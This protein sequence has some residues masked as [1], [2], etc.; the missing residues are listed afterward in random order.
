[1]RTKLFIF[2]FCCL[3]V[4]LFAQT[5]SGGFKVTGLLL[6]SLSREPVAYATIKIASESHPQKAVKMLVTD[7]KG[8]FE[9][10]LPGAGKY[11][12]T[13]SSVGNRTEVRL[14][15]VSQSQPKA[16]LGTV[17]ISEATEELG[18]VTV[19]AQKP[20]VKVEVDKIAYDVESDPDAQD[21]TVLDMLRKVPL[22]TVDGEDNIKL[23]GKTNFRIHL[24][25]RPSNL[26]S[27]NPG[28]TLKSMP[29][30]SVKDIEVITSPGAKYD[31][32]GV[33]GIINIVT[34]SG[35][36]LEGYS[37]TLTAGSNQNGS[38][39]A[40]VS[41]VVKVG[42]LSVSG[43]YNH[44]YYRMPEIP[45]YS[46]VDY[47]ADPLDHR[48]NINSHTKYR[49]PMDYGTAEAS[50]EIDSLNLLTFTLGAYGGR[51]KSIS[52]GYT[53]MLDENGLPRYRYDT[54]GNSNQ[55]FGGPELSLNYQRTLSK[56][57]EL[58]TVSYRFSRTP[59]GGSSY[60]RMTPLEGTFPFGYTEQ[61]SDNDAHTNEH[62]AQVDYINPFRKLHTIEAGVKFIFRDTY[63][64]S[65]YQIKEHE[66][67]PWKPYP[68]D[69]TNFDHNQNILSAYA[70]YTLKYKNMGLKLGARLEH[71]KLDVMLHSE[72][73]PDFDKKFTDVVP[74]VNLS[75]KL[76]DT[77]TLRAGYNMRISRP[78]I[79]FLNPYR[80]E[81]N[82]HFISYGNPD[83][84]S[85]KYQNLDVS[86]S[87]FTQRVMLNVSL[88][89]N[90][91]HNSIQQYNRL[92]ESTG[93]VHTTYANIGKQNNVSLGVYGNFTPFDGT[94]I[95]LNGMV[96]YNDLR[97][98]D[99]SLVDAR[100]KG[101]QGGGSAGLQQNLPWKLQLSAFGGYY[102]HDIQ[103]QTR[104]VDYFYYGL[105]L[106]RNFLKEDRLTVSLS[107]F[108][109]LNKLHYES[110]TETSN[111]YQ[112][113]KT[114]NDQRSVNLT[115]SFRL[116]DLRTVVKKVARGITN[117][118]LKSGGGSG[119]QQGGEK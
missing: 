91:C 36:G 110:T 65:E 93:V 74:T 71:S 22:V 11:Q 102:I 51:S 72:E 78:G 94:N 43:Y 116:G 60:L 29:A 7:V 117:D 106:R 32:E 26:L 25:G 108:N 89:Y 59:S 1:M 85:E 114:V 80:D 77:Q 92:D 23:N 20:L 82:P 6:D 8:R 2:F 39:N 70:A 98:S 90:F 104:G 48:L 10:T 103:L 47:F 52:G 30:N 50:Y 68:Q 19:L 18:G 118:D 14:F 58:L 96:S 76:S 97:S 44:S 95:W 40:G 119:S 113:N 99:P 105:T 21:K 66:N 88:S 81:N 55:K 5:K 69:L 46:T 15:E 87:N 42:K 16:D 37:A 45:S 12:I 9:D 17:Y 111:Y 79:W 115:V 84:E 49:Q 35:K 109:F 75:F 112:W 34:Q 41:A 61:Y 27:S 33:G 100:A 83:L 38:W 107:A 86:Y 101:W 64:K 31:A 56:K 3:S 24:N 57:E 13:F 4:A 28:K 73:T 53:E 62:T 63:S 54:E 67:E